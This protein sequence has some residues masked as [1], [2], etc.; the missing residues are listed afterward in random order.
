MGR[1]RGSTFWATI[2]RISNKGNGVINKD[3]GG[4]LNVGAVKEEVVGQT[5]E[6]RKLGHNKAELVDPDLRKDV[7]AKQNESE[8]EDITIG[9]IISGRI[10]KQTPDGTPVLEKGGT[11]I[12]VPDAKLNETVEIEI[13][14]F[15]ETNSQWQIALGKRTT[16][17]DDTSEEGLLGSVQSDVVLYD[18]LTT[19]NSG[20]VTCPAVDCSYTGQPASVAGHVSGKRDDNHKWT[21]LGYDGANAYKSTVTASTE[22]PEATTHLLHL[23]DS[24]LGASLSTNSE[25]SNESRCLKGF[26]RAIDIAIDQEVDGVFNTGDFFH[27]DRHGIPKEVEEAARNQLQR[28]AKREIPFYSIDGDHERNEG[29][30]VLK[31]FER[32]GL[33]IAL[34]EE[35]RLVGDGI[36]LYGRDYTQSKSWTGTDWSPQPQP[37]NRYSILALHQSIAPISNSDDPDCTVKDVATIAKPHVQAIAT[38]HLHLTGIRWQQELPFVLGG[39]T[40]PERAGHTSNDPVVGLFIQTEGGSLRYQRLKLSIERRI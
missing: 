40:E 34:S 26:Q 16:E 3:G 35:P 1:G 14:S 21:K 29:R 6:V 5:V 23:T 20:T 37:G 22:P 19:S 30:E 32:E 25:Y 10:T 27:N 7:F 12:K 17:T 13:E 36:A 18:E 24:H 8:T 31:S 9:E 33:V 2:D 11:R 4:H 15:P 28:L 38:G 39:T